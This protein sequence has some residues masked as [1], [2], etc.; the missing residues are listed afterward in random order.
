MLSPQPS[1]FCISISPE[2]G[3]KKENVDRAI[4]VAGA[5]ILGDIHGSTD[6]PV[7]LLPYESFTRLAHPTLKITPGDFAENITTI[8][9]DL[10]RL[11]VGAR[12]MLG[13]TALVEVIQI[14]KECHDECEIRRM[15]GDCIMPH[16]GVF[17]RV[18]GGGEV[19]PGDPIKVIKSL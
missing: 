15:A 8:G 2:L 19:R 12:L 18:L 4:L 1:I 3:R 5:G 6:R 7:S 9:L 13:E 17:V 10:S 11:K 14:G 16:E